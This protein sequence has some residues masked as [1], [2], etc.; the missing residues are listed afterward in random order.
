MKV[1]LNNVSDLQ[2]FVND[3][4]HFNYEII[5]ERGNYK[6]NAKSIMGLLSLDLSE[7]LEI[8]ILSDNENIISEF[9]KVGEKY[10]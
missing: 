7:P 9:K 10:V 4:S 3:I 1:N 2:K 6:V 8:N 5:A